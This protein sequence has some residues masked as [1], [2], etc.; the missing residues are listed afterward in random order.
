MWGNIKFLE[1]KMRKVIVLLECLLIC[2]KLGAFYKVPDR[3]WGSYSERT[4]KVVNCPR[5]Y[6]WTL[7]LQ[8]SQYILDTG[9][10]RQNNGFYRLVKANVRTDEYKDCLLEAE[11]LLK[12]AY[13]IDSES[14][15]LLYKPFNGD[16]LIDRMFNP[17]TIGVS[18]SYVKWSNPKGLINVGF[19]GKNAQFSLESDFH[20]RYIVS[21]KAGFD[22][23]M[24]TKFVLNPFRKFER[25]NGNVY[26]QNKVT[27]S[28]KVK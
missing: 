6:E 9:I 24:S 1:V 11:Y 27:V 23:P 8:N 14:L 21:Y 12:E 25:N 2:G 7:G 26:D 5:D 22:I 4:S 3:V 16:T 10:E 17:L 13:S 19:R 18:L 28:Y 15:R 20:S